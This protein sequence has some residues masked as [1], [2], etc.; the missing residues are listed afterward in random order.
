MAAPLPEFYCTVDKL[1]MNNYLDIYL[2]MAYTYVVN[3]GQDVHK[4]T[5][6]S[7]QNS[8]SSQRRSIPPEIREIIPFLRV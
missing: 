7:R 1:W 4:P 2:S 3:Q 5:P 6:Y 8:S